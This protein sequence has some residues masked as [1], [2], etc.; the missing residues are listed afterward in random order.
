MAHREVDTSSPSARVSQVVMGVVLAVISAPLMVIV[1]RLT[2]DVGGVGVPLGLLLAGLFQ[3]LACVFLWAS[4]DSRLPLV[5]LLAVWGIVA[6]PFLG[7]GA[8][9]GILVPAQLG[10]QPQY[11]GVLVQLLGVGIP[12]AMLAILTLIP[13]VKRYRARASGPGAA[14][15]GE[16]PASTR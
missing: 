14:A 7:R 10:G 12:L 13:L 6:L 15:A 5:V 4:T 1:H 2:L 3:L 8:G 11:G 9:G 16:G